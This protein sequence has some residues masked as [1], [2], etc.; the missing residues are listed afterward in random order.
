MINQ[1]DENFW[2]ETVKDVEK[3]PSPNVVCVSKKKITI[4]KSKFQTVP[5]VIYKHDID[6]GISS[7]IDKHTMRKF[8]R[9]EF[10]VEGVLDL[11]GF[12]EDMAYPAVFNF[13]TSSYLAKKR[14]VL[15]ITGKGSFHEND[16]IFAPKGVLKDR[17]PQWLKTDELKQLILSYIHPSEKLG[18]SGALYILLRRN[19]T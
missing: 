10:G 6:L 11:H 2:L 7:D 4:K 18:G 13:I 14:C 16:D 17:V 5:L 9:E 12:T 19:R 1:E 3:T 15:I 8:K